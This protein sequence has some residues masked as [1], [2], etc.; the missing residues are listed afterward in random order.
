MV[1]YYEKFDPEYRKFLWWSKKELKKI[2]KQHYQD[3]DEDT[4]DEY[5]DALLKA[6][7]SVP[8]FRPDRVD[9]DFNFSTFISCGDARGMEQAVYEIGDH[10]QKHRE[11]VMAVWKFLC[12]PPADGFALDPEL[13]DELLGLKSLKFSHPSRMMAHK[14]ALFDHQILEL[15]ARQARMTK[16]QDSSISLYSLYDDSSMSSRSLSS[17]ASSKSRGGKEE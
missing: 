3:L 12:H 15:Y 4:E 17:M 5:G 7:D 8:Y 10:V 2:Y 11:E 13:K 14:L 6:Y 16:S 9:P 1:R